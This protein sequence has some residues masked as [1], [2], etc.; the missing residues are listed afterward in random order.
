MRLDPFR[1]EAYRDRRYVA[2]TRKQ[3]AG[4]GEMQ[5]SSATT[6]A[7]LTRPTGASRGNGIP[8]AEALVDVR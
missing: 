7:V 8:V 2:L 4:A 3:F 5:R 6:Y 1:R